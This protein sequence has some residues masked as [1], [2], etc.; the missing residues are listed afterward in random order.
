MI[1]TE[2]DQVLDTM[3]VFL[4]SMMHMESL[5]ATTLLTTSAVTLDAYLSGF[6]P[7]FR[8]TRIACLP[9]GGKAKLL[10][11]LWPF[12]GTIVSP[13]KLILP[14]RVA[15]SLPVLAFMCLLAVF[16]DCCQTIRRFA[17]QAILRR[18]LDLTAASTNLIRWGG[19]VVRP[20]VAQRFHGASIL[21]TTLLMRE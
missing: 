12:T 13:K 19:S 9:S 2:C 4:F 10:L 7:G 14:H 8:L 16:A 1:G 18:S 15:R 3:V 21:P 11:P 20:L 17:I 5:L 6:P